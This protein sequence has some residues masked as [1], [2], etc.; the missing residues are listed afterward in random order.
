MCLV[1]V[2]ALVETSDWMLDW[3]SLEECWEQESDCVWAL[4][5]N[6]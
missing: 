1:G 5:T 3:M 6:W 2:S 4:S